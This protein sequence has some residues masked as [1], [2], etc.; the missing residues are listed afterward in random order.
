MPTDQR[1]MVFL[2]A[3]AATVL[4]VVIG[5]LYLSGTVIAS[6]GS[7]DKR[8]IVCFVVAVVAALIAFVTR[9]VGSRIAR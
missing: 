5:I 2:V 8:A 7:H 9:P 3:C 4:L 1:Q 6:G